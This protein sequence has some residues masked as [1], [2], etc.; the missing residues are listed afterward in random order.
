MWCTL[1][2]RELTD[3]LPGFSH[4]GTHFFL[5][6]KNNNQSSHSPLLFFFIFF[7]S[8]YDVK[9]EAEKHPFLVFAAL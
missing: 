7:F 1:K 5:S 6:K 4:E 9:L 3:F 8:C 2:K